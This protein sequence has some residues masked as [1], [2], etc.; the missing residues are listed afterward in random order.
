MEDFSL[1]KAVV[2]NGSPNL[3]MQLVSL[4]C[5]QSRD[6]FV[7][8]MDRSISLQRKQSKKEGKDQESIHQAP[9]LTQNTNG[10]VTTSQ[11]D[12]TNESQ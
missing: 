4:R 5:L 2:Q 1:S 3:R 12:I 11:L 6:C 8:L 7:L 10:K 9:H